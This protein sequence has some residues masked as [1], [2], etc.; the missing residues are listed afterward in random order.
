MQSKRAWA[1][2]NLDYLTENVENIKSKITSGEYLG[3]VKA[4]AYGHGSAII[5]RH[6]E[7]L[8]INHFAVSN[9]DEAIEL[10]RAGIVGEIIILGYTDTGVA[11][12][13]FEQNIVQAVFSLSY[14]KELNAAAKSVGAMVNCCLAVDTG[15]GRI[16]FDC[17]S[18]EAII[19]SA[20]IMAEVCSLSHLAVKGMFTHFAVADSHEET[21]VNFTKEQ[22]DRIIKAASEVSM[23]IGKPLII[24]AANT[25]GTLLHNETQNSLNRIGISMYG[26]TPAEGL[27]LP[28]KL[29]PVM[30]LKAVISQIK[31]IKP[32]ETVSY[33]R[34]FTAEKETTVATVPVG[35]ADG[36]CRNL[37][38]KADVFINGKRARVIGR[39]CMDQLMVDVTN[40]PCRE[41]DTVE[42]FGENIRAE[43]LANIVG[44][45]NYEIVTG[46]SRRVPRVYIKGGKIVRIENY[47]LG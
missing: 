18:D 4:D 13:L 17:R 12:D 40:V 19:P 45:I 36:Y 15:M 32:G 35:Y 28:V 46:I 31:T 44:T 21:D 41:G 37:S 5:S 23:R 34:T 3:V 14:A 1:E 8:K 38:N 25:A 24:H 42:L 2:I 26:L 9:I 22:N 29:K 7:K 43:E 10:R 20:E 39:V 16:G 47:L 30:S 6:L 33:G 27:I 11:I